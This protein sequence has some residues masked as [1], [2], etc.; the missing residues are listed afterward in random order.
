M[1]L[2]AYRQ[3]ALVGLLTVPLLPPAGVHA[4]PP[5]MT[6]STR[7]LVM[8]DDV[9]PPIMPGLR[10][11]S[12]SVRSGFDEPEHRTSTP[13]PG[14][15]SD[16]TLAG[17]GGG[18]AV[19]TV[20][21]TA[22]SGERFTVVLPAERWQLQGNPSN[23]L[24]YV[25][26]GDPATEPVWKVWLKRTKVTVR[27]GKQHWG[28]SLDEPAQGRIAIRLTLGTGITYCAEV[29]PRTTGSPPSSASFDR[30][31]MFKGQPKTPPP[32]ECPPL[33]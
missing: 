2:R 5:I 1:H 13:E 9:T 16:P 3:A 27:G 18:G 11:F 17:A 24:R 19:L 14:S 8:R 21:N 31:G 12:W 23:G 30:P 32:A 28:Y 20:Y 7:V 15:A 33:P 4:D 6:V 29:P 26:V 25:Y 22:G 10:A